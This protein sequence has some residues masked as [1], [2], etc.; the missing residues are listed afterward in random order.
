MIKAV[1]T[2]AT[3]DDPIARFAEQ[4]EDV[5]SLGNAMKALGF[6]YVDEE[7]SNLKDKSQAVRTVTLAKE[8]T[9]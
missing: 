9:R 6:K 4:V 1:F 2:I 8:Y 3:K 7:S 5:A